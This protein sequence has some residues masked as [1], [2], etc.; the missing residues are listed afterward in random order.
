MPD[1]IYLWAWCGVRT[2]SWK[3]KVLWPHGRWIRVSSSVFITSVS[4]AVSTGPG[5]QHG[6]PP[7]QHIHP[8]LIGPSCQRV[9]EWCFPGTQEPCRHVGALWLIWTWLKPPSVLQG[10]LA[11][12]QSRTITGQETRN[13]GSNS[14]SATSSL[15][16]PGPSQAWNSSE[17]QFLPLEKWDK[18]VRRCLG[19]FQLLQADSRTLAASEWLLWVSKNQK[20]WTKASSALSY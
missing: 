4:S 9:W 12:G 11:V 3:P 1:K 5:T 19:L 6:P 17:S 15:G 16:E 7:I 2:S 20:V 10:V 14:I 18:W 13:L 8:T